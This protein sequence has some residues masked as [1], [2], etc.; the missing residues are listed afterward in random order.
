MVCSLIGAHGVSRP[1]PPL[2]MVLRARAI[3]ISP[4]AILV[5]FLFSTVASLSLKLFIR[6]SNS[7]KPERFIVSLSAIVRD[8]FKGV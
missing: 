4:I 8:V 5:S 6:R 1:V 7:S 2:L 3:R